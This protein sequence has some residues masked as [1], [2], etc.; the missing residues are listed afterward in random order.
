MKEVLSNV[1]KLIKVKTL[2]T[3][4]VMVLFAV[5]VIRGNVPPD[6]LNYIVVM[7]ISFYFGTQTEKGDK[8]LK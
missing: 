7:V 1:A 8:I 5:E 2:V 3:V 4:A 6:M